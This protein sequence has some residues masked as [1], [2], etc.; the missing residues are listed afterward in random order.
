MTSALKLMEDT[1]ARLV[2][3]HEIWSTLIAGSL[4]VPVAVVCGLK[5]QIPCILRSVLNNEDGHGQSPVLTTCHMNHC[6]FPIKTLPGQ[7]DVIAPARPSLCN[8]VI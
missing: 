5:W 6:K 2:C 4:N 7:K 1:A 3:T 8:L